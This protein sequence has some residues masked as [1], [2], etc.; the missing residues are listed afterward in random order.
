MNNLKDKIIKII[1]IAMIIA[2]IVVCLI[3]FILDGYNSYVSSD[4]NIDYSFVST[5]LLLSIAIHFILSAFIQED[6]LKKQLTLEEKLSQS[7]D[8]IIES[9][10][11]VEVTFFDDI[12]DVDIYIAKQIL[13]ATSSVYDFN[14]QDYTSV[15]PHHRSQYEKEYASNEIDKS[16]KKFCE[17]NSSISPIYKEIFT[18]SYPKNWGKLLDHISYG[19]S[20]SC[21]YY[22]N[23]DD[24]KFPKLQ[25][26]VIDDKEVIFVSSA[27]KPNLCSIKNKRIVSIFSSY[28]DQAWDLSIKIKESNQLYDDIVSDIKNKYV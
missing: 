5:T 11:G 20:Y 13:E 7:T 17:R 8:T 19:D 2:A 21:S 24:K 3:A 16:I 26:V 6:I 12:N 1:D 27:Y 28:F 14:W 9:L 23:K 25:F 10:N 4:I 22:D 18:F 15:N